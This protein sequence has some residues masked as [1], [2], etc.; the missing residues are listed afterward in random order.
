M[1]KRS[2]LPTI[3][4]RTVRECVSK[5]AVSHSCPFLLKLFSL[6]FASLPWLALVAQLPFEST[7]HWYVNQFT[8]RSVLTQD[9]GRI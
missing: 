3:R 4:L 9:P 8:R 7:S 5:L 6:R 2:A 1:L